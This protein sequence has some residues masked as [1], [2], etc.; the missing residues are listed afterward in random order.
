[1]E[2][3]KHA[4]LKSNFNEKVFCSFTTSSFILV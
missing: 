4:K 1:M 2:K 3:F